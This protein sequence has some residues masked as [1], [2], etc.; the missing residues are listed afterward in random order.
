MNQLSCSSKLRLRTTTESPELANAPLLTARSDNV[1]GGALAPRT[2]W[3]AGA[4]RSRPPNGA[5]W[6]GK[7]AEAAYLR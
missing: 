5:R 7:G 3:L 6:K 2:A 1:D 4:Y